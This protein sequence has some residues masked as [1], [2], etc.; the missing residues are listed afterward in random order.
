MYTSQ[1]GLIHCVVYVFEI[2]KVKSS[3]MP[4]DS[5][6]VFEKPNILIQGKKPGGPLCTLCMLKNPS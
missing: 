2:G 5:Q 1:S 6:I 3:I 4:S